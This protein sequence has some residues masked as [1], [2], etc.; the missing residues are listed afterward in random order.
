M[1]IVSCQMLSAISSSTLSTLLPF[2][3]VEISSRTCVTSAGS[4]A[5][6]CL[7]HA[8]AITKAALDPSVR[9]AVAACLD[10][11]LSGISDP[12]TPFGGSM[13]RRMADVRRD[14]CL[15]G[16]LASGHLSGGSMNPARS[17]GPALAGSLGEH[18][19]DGLSN[20]WVYFLG[21]L[22]G[23]SIAGACRHACV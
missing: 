7:L 13:K 4:S 10:M 16:I 15:Q 22:L 18:T 21:P 14:V 19:G 3:Y 1:H 9:I 8:A 17:F 11:C 5:A 12:A 2:L 6:V 23:A 20:L